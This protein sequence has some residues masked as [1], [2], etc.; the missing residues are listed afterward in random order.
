MSQEPADGPLLELRQNRGGAAIAAGVQL[1]FLACILALG[2][3]YGVMALWQAQVV[4][5]LVSAWML[6]E[7]WRSW[8]VARTGEPRFQLFADRIEYTGW[9]DPELPLARV[10][11]WEWRER[12]QATYLVF[13]LLRDADGAKEER[14]VP[15]DPYRA[16]LTDKAAVLNATLNQRLAACNRDSVP[17]R[18]LRGEITRAPGVPRS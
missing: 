6:R 14:L 11:N 16:E 13:H 8:R 17:A 2:Y 12:R 4:G 7:G 5:V 18:R 3:A 9:P 10:R 1:L 15:M